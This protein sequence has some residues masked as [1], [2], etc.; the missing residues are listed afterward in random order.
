MFKIFIQSH[1]QETFEL[2]KKN[3]GEYSWACPILIPNAEEN[4]PYFENKLFIDFFDI[5]KPEE[6][7]LIDFIGSLSYKAYKVNPKE[8]D[9]YL[10]KYGTDQ[11]FIHFLAHP[12]RKVNQSFLNGKDKFVEIWKEC[13]ENEI[14][15]I[16]ETP[17][18]FRNY[19]MASKPLF[20]DYCKFL[21][22]FIVKV[23]EHPLAMQ[24]S[25][26][27]GGKLTKQK[28]LKLCGV[29]HYPILPFIIERCT[30]GYFLKQGLEL[31]RRKGSY[32]SLK[33]KDFKKI[34]DLKVKIFILCHTEERYL[35]A[36]TIYQ[37]Y[38]WAYPI[39]TIYN[40]NLCE[41]GFWKQLEEIKEEWE[42]FE[43]VGT[44][45]YTAFE[46]LNLNEVNKFIIFKKWKND[47]YTHFLP[48]KKELFSETCHEHLN[49][50]IKDV[51]LKL[52]NLK[53]KRLHFSNYWMTTPK[54]MLEFL[55]W[56][57]NIL[58]PE[59]L[60]H[61]LIN[62]NPNYKNKWSNNFNYSPFV[63]ERMIPFYFT[64]YCAC[65]KLNPIKNK[66]ENIIVY[67]Y[68]ETNESKENLYFF[69]KHGLHTENN[70]LF[71]INGM[72]CSVPIPFADNIQVWKRYESQADII[73]FNH[74]FKEY[75]NEIEMYQNYFFINSSCRG[76][77]LPNYYATK[78]NWVN[79]YN[80]LLKDYSAVVPVIEFPPNAIEDETI[81]L[82]FFHTYMF[83]VN[84]LGFEC[85]RKTLDVQNVSIIILERRIGRNFFINKLPIKCLQS[86]FKNVDIN[87]EE[88][89]KLM[90]PPSGRT[91][92]EIPENY[93]G[94]DLHPFEVIFLK[95]V[96]KVN[97]NRSLYNSGISNVLHKQVKCYS[98]WFSL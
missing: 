22:D 49:T 18:C 16:Y 29:P 70:Y 76:P 9:Q 42:N 11:D 71:I 57:Q 85:L 36:Q 54:L 48:S 2:A 89:W 1:N 17:A 88:N 28:L 80:E 79:I 82:P 40:G 38:S 35:E 74:L 33:L 12:T 67:C 61:P 34:E 15:S 46:K 8:V 23:K 56:V 26:Y 27:Y 19:W 14:G 37:Q 3:F 24:N 86:R 5:V 45:S 31:F 30:I 53:Y 52:P 77:F 97:A 69:I 47:E 20:L 25:N 63:L 60:Q 62:E 95:N 96:R 64:D 92:V 32:L 7:E 75:K 94:I 78:N 10:S 65:C 44:L 98:E 6:Y 55:P 68:N 72:E 91:C 39:K 21:K 51:L 43:R 58:I 59:V 73:T 41:N 50:I 13:C 66:S 87:L 90:Q 83:A 93:F 81:N 4:N 84:K